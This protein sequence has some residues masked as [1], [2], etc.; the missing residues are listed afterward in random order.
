MSLDV[1]TMMVLFAVLALMFSGLLA[2][3]TLHAGNIRG[4]RQWA[5]ANLFM[6]LGLGFSYFFIPQ[7][8]LSKFAV[9]LGAILI[10]AGVALQ[11]TGIQAF[12]VTR[13]YKGLAVIFVGIVGLQTFWFEFIQPDIAFR[14]IANSIAFALGYA[15]C[16]HA[17][18]I[19]IDPPLRTA[20]WFTGLSFAALSAALLIR[21]IVISQFHLEN[22]SLYSNTPLNPGLF[23]LACIIQLCVTFGF[24]LMLNYRLLMEIQKIASLDILTGAFNRRRIEEEAERLKARSKRTGDTLAVMMIDVDQFK[25]INDSY[26]HPIGDEVLRRLTEIA[27]ASIR[28]DDYFAR[29]GGEEF[30]ILLPSTSAIEAY[31]LAERLRITYESTTMRIA[32]KAIKSTISVGVADSSQV[33]L[34]FEALIG[35]AD[36]ALYRAKQEG[37][38]KVV[39]FLEEPDSDNLN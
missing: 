16:A 31:G 39:V 14:S 1:R 27:H 33:G 6:S 2:L 24:L 3:A 18:L 9:V 37:R 5:F 8:P 30:C 38:N 26:G 11:F 15:A 28:A 29:Y 4:I 34:E 23:L 13:T 21:G 10:A 35:A 36:Q 17:L 7:T 19:R 22:Y 20:F 25:S 12:K 32:G